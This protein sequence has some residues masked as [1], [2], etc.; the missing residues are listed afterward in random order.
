M[1]HQLCSAPVT[2]GRSS[3]WT[4]LK[5][6]KVPVKSCGRTPTKR[7]NSF[8]MAKRFV[9]GFQSQFADAGDALREEFQAGFAPDQCMQDVVGAEHVADVMA[10]DRGIH[11]LRDEVDRAVVLIGLGDGMRIVQAG[12]ESKWGY[13]CR[14]AA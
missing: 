3:G 6:S 8:D 2:S 5:A 12:E 4:R 10:Q 11:R 7:H 1:G 14:A 13:V 9:L